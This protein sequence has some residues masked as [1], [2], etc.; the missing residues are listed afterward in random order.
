MF[1]AV[2]SVPERRAKIESQQEPSKLPVTSAKSCC[3]RIISRHGSP[4]SSSYEKR[5]WHE[6]FPRVIR[7]R[8]EYYVSVCATLLVSEVSSDY[9]GI[10][11]DPLFG[12]NSRGGSLIRGRFVSRY[13]PYSPGRSSST[14]NPPSPRS[15]AATRRNYPRRLAASWRCARF[16]S[17][18]DSLR[19]KG[20]WDS[21]AEVRTFEEC[22]RASRV[23]DR[24]CHCVLCLIQEICFSGE[25]GLNS[26]IIGISWWV[27]F[28]AW[29]NLF[30]FGLSILIL[31]DKL[32]WQFVDLVCII[33]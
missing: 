9:A 20:Y 18:I 24:D 32:I 5:V 23:R 6:I 31:W 13:T 27:R 28:V 1:E 7:L 30:N 10:S 33:K 2:H 21:L 14:S 19:A 8:R 4:S 16:E 3:R 25:N 22:L 29:F 11:G 15:T 12:I 26:E 17:T